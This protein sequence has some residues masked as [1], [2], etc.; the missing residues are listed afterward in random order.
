MLMQL[1]ML[2]RMRLQHHK[3][4]V[5]LLHYLIGFWKKEVW[6]MALDIKSI[7]ELHIKE[8]ILKNYVMNLREVSMFK[9][10]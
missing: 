4:V 6:F 5:L 9:V 3:V 2:I 10:I 8:L 7:S 1:N